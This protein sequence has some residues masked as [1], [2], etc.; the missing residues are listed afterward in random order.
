MQK[1]ANNYL[2][3]KS[4]GNKMYKCLMPQYRTCTTTTEADDVHADTRTCHVDK[5]PGMY[6]GRL[7][8]QGP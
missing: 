7:L 6:M 3:P 2:D 8:P 1:C 4:F 5:L